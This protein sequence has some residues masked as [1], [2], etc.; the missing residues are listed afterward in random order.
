MLRRWQAVLVA[1]AVTC[2]LGAHYVIPRFPPAAAEALLVAALLYILLASR[3]ALAAVRSMPPGQRLVAATLVGAVLGGHFHA[4]VYNTFPFVDWDI[5][6][7]VMGG[8]PHFLDYYATRE[9]GAEEQLIPEDLFPVLRKKLAVQ[10][11]QLADA[12][13]AGG[14]PQRRETLVR[15]Y[16]GL[17]LAMARADRRQHPGNPLVTLR[18]EKCTIPLEDYAGRNSIVCEPFWSWNWA[19]ERE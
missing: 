19:R 12:I 8:D 2:G 18:I 15:W 10:L 6:A 4:R 13:E 3:P 16:E 14:E 9:D 11:E 17:L 7:Q 5:Y 1:L